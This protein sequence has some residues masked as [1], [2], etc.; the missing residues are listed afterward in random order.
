M[1]KLN[2]LIVGPDNLPGFRAAR[3]EVFSEWYPDG[4][5]PAHTLAVVAG[6]AAPELL[7]EIEAILAVPEATANRSGAAFR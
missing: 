5:V 4:D 6:L 3:D 2:T 1:A 7:V